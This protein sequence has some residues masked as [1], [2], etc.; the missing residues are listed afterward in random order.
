M[1]PCFPIIYTKFW[2]YHVWIPKCIELLP[3]D[4]MITYLLK[5]AV[6]QWMGEY[7]SLYIYI[8]LFI[9][10]LYLYSLLKLYWKDDRGIVFT[11]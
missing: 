9:Y 3:C 5:K 7:M 1:D 2:P 4:C 8:I 6:V 11:F 10:L